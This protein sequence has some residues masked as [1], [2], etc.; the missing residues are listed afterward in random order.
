LSQTR[1]SFRERD[2]AICCGNCAQ[3]RN[4]S[5]C[6]TRSTGEVRTY[7]CPE[8]GQL[9]VTV[10]HSAARRGPRDDIGADNWLS[11]HPASDL[12]V[13]LKDSRLTIP[14]VQAGRIFGE[15]LL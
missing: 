12:L 3:E 14:P 2:F 10:G 9:L 8:C 7:R 5:Q 4:L 6:R 13:Q 1:H 11:I 15:P